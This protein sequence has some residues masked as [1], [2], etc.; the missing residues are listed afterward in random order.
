MLENGTECNRKALFQLLPFGRTTERF[1]GHAICYRPAHSEIEWELFRFTIRGIQHEE[2]S[3]RAK[4]VQCVPKFYKNIR[5]RCR[6][7][8]TPFSPVNDGNV[9]HE[10][11][12]STDLVED[13]TSNL[14]RSRDSTGIPVD[15]RLNGERFVA[16]DR[17]HG[18]F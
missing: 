18:L 15:Y 13:G 10:H 14:G 4:C 8:R 2:N 5:V 9:C 6:S 12:C 1:L 17:F 16:C 11:C 3:S 7:A